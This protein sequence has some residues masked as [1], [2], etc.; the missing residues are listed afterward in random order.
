MLAE[1]AIKKHL[2]ENETSKNSFAAQDNQKQ[3]K[4]QQ[5]NEGDLNA[6]ISSTNKEN[7]YDPGSRP[8]S[9]IASQSGEESE[10]DDDDREDGR[11]YFRFD[12]YHEMQQLASMQ[13]QINENDEMHEETV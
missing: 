9:G 1:M 4:R 13:Q 10:S 11:I 12:E 5:A 3:H 6:M 8:E 2:E 7:E